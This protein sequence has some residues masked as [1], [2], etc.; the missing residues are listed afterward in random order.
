MPG[1]QRVLILAE[2]ANPEW[3]SVPLVGWSHA[4]AL[5]DACDAH[6]VTQV[7]NRDAILRAGLVEGKDF[8]AINSEAAARKAQKLSHILRG[9][10]KSGVSWTT[11]TALQSLAYPYFEKL[12]WRQFGDRIKRHE[13]DVVHRITPLSP[14]SPSPIASKCARAGVPFVLGP[15]NGGVPWPKEFSSAR[16]KEKEWLSYVRG[17]YKLMPGYRS[18]RRKSAAILLASRDTWSQMPAKYRDKCFYLPE[19]AIDPSR[20]QKRRCR[21][22]TQPIKG[23]FIGRLVPYKGADML[24]EAACEL[25]RDVL[26]T[27][28][29]VGDGPQMAELRE[30]VSREK[31]E[32][33]VML[34]GWVEHAKVQDRLVEADVLCFP[35]IREFG[36]GV[37]L[38]AMAVG[39]VPVVPR[40]GG[41]GELVTDET[42]FLIEM[43]DRK[44]MIA[45]LRQTLE[46]LVETPSLID[47]K[48][49]VAFRRAHEQ[50]T[51]SAKAQQTLKVYDWVTGQNPQRPE[52]LPP[53]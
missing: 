16:R 40:Y 35:S 46:Q 8:T 37:A 17:A 53:A 21:K 36:G 13:F 23:I 44:T 24:L 18:T 12:V 34:S 27:V 30:M 32:R 26:M 38:E 4:R 39:V 6:L 19:N 52:M 20:F 51:W 50:F 43:G 5:M 49:D 9:G 22:A 7:R 2:A 48:S 15:L 11:V 29:I 10:K 3:V 14:T 41:L 28:E 42:G 31:L 1:K 45:R 33:P 25:L 47:A